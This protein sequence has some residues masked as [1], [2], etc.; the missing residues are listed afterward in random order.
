MVRDAKAA[1]R[2][3]VEEEA[4]RLPGF[5]GAYLAGSLRSRPDGDPFP[6]S[7]D[8]DL[9]IVLDREIPEQFRACDLHPLASYAP[10]SLDRVRRGSVGLPGLWLRCAHPAAVGFARCRPGERAE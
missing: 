6:A 9:R 3:W 5:L 7:S 4:S 2:S 1:A 10:P 8:V